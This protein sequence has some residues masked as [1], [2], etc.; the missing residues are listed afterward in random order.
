MRL[1]T[2]FWK[3]IRFATAFVTIVSLVL[4][5]KYLTQNPWTV[6]HE[7]IQVGLDQREYRLTIPKA[8]GKELSPVVIVLHGALDTVEETAIHSGLDVLSAEGCL[9]AYLQGL[10]MNWPP[11]IPASNPNLA[12]PDIEFFHSVCNHLVQEEK[13]DPD[14]IYLVGVSQGGGMANLLVANCSELI[15][16][17]VCNCGWLPKPL[18]EAPLSTEYPC[19]MLFISGAEDAQVPP[20]MVRSAMRAFEDAGHPC[21]FLSLPGKGHGWNNTAV[22]I[23]AFLQDKSK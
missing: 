23:W 22:P 10:H 15:A 5:Y 18:D 12:Q 1:R 21:T 3:T 2:E 4:T 11:F 19:P 8:R 13:A 16:A 14:R 7:K 20:E 6:L 9:V 17:A